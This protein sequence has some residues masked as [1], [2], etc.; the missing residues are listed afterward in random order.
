MQSI[1][2]ILYEATEPTVVT[3]KSKELSQKA[4]QFYRAVEKAF[5]GAFAD[6]F[7]SVN[8][9]LAAVESKAAF[10]RGFRLCAQLFSEA[11]LSRYSS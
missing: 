10:V 1:I 9:A 7:C 3:G 4:S 2:D 6:E 8:A 11:T 5:G